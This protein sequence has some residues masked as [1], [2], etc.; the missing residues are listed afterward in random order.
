[1]TWTP[2]AAERFRE[3]FAASKRVL[4]GAGAGLSV[5]AGIDYGDPISFERLF[6]AMVRRGFR[7]RYQ[8]IGYTGLSPAAHWGYWARHVH[9]VRFTTRRAPV[10][11]GLRDLLK[12]KDAFVLTSNVDAMFARHGFDESRLLTPQ[13]DYAAMQCMTQAR[14]DCRTAVWPSRPIVER[15]LAR[16]DPTTQEVTDPDVLPRCPHCGGAVFLN[17]RLTDT[18]VE[19]PYA[20]Q[21]QRFRSW[22]QTRPEAPLLV[23]EIG[24]GFNTPSVVRWPLEGIVHHGARAHFVR[25]NLEHPDV[26]PGITS[27]S[28]ALR[29]DALEAVERLTA[30]RW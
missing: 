22:I 2:E 5:A 29:I 1:M 9:D 14:P 8:L 26:P 6:P 11:E 21:R 30:A 28:L 19:A 17:V 24:A 10:Y 25:I 18:F 7:A 3:W 20:E 16:I 12:D 15:L 13:G 27:R 23:I 4:I